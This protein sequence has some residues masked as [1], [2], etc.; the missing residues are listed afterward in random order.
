MGTQSCKSPNLGKTTRQNVIWMWASWRGTK[1][2]IRG[3]VVA[4]PKFGSWWVQVCPWLVLAPKVFKLCIN[5]LVVWFVQV[6]MSN[7][8]LSLFLVP[9]SELQHALLPPKCCEPGNMP[10]LLAL[11]LFSPYTHIWIYKGGWE[12]VTRAK[13]LTKH[14]STHGK[15]KT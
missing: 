1:Y 7:W 12:R 9:I 13:K 3:K 8:C 14:V 2:I 11:P 6:R 4:S 10:Q 5:Q 15:R